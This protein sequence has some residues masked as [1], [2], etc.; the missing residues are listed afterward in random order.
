MNPTHTMSDQE[1]RML[2]HSIE[3]ETANTY[4]AAYARQWQQIAM[5]NAERRVYLRKPLGWR[6]WFAREQWASS[7][8]RNHRAAIY[9]AFG[10]VVIAT[11]ATITGVSSWQEDQM[12][13]EV[14][15]GK[16][17]WRI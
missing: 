6:R 10:P 17:G 16:R 9:R 14:M 1:R 3:V 11:T 7:P 13:G 12:F 15:N 8:G 5:G 4:N 2:T